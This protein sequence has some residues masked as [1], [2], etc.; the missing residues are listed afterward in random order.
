VYRP[1][2]FILL[3]LVVLALVTGTASVRAAEP[4]WVQVRS[5]DFSVVTD[6]GEKRGREVALR[7]EQMRKVF[8]TLI[9]KEKVN[10]PVS[11]QIIAFSNRKQMRDYA[12]LFNGKPIELAGGFPTDDSSPPQGDMVSLELQ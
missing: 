5:P 9:L 8:G 7:F 10:V 12:P 6:A 1:K 2:A 3:F 11:L 4:Q